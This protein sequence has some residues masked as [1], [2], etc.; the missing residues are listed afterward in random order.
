MDQTKMITD[1]INKYQD[2]P[3]IQSDLKKM[4]K[5]AESEFRTFCN[6]F[7]KEQPRP[8]HS[9][10]T[11]KMNQ[12]IAQ[13]AGLGPREVLGAVIAD[14]IKGYHP[15]TAAAILEAISEAAAAADASDED[16]EQAIPNAV[17]DAGAKLL[18]AHAEIDADR[19]RK[20]ATIAI[21]A[22]AA[23]AVKGE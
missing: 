9:Q 3:E 12:L 1:L 23:A 8:A 19:F 11:K 16:A 21:A 4:L 17:R 5:Y 18:E 14:A 20:D 6:Q 2:T 13:V 7:L 22:S 10:R 15:D